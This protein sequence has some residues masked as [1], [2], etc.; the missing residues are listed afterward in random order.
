MINIYKASAGA[1]KTHKLTGEYLKLLFSDYNAYS[2]ILAVTFTNKATDEM[3]QRILLELY[4][5]SNPNIKSDYIDDL[6]TLYNKSHLDIRIQAKKILLEILYDY[7]AFSIS[8][9]D[10]F[11][12]KIMRAFARELGRNLT[13]EVEL[14]T[15]KVLNVVVDTMFS[16]LDLPEN[17]NLLNWLIKY[18][19]EAVE[20]GNSWNI[21]K[22]II[23]LSNELFSESF[24]LKKGDK[25]F[26]NISKFKDTL[27][28]IRKTFI[29]ELSKLIG[30]GFSIMDSFDLEYDDFKGGSRSAFKYFTINRFQENVLIKEPTAS[31]R[32]LYNDF[33]SKWFTGKEPNPNILSAYNS[34]LNDC[35]G[36]ILKHFDTYYKLYITSYVILN[37]INALGILDEVYMR[38]VNYCNQKN[39]MLIS[40]STELLNKIIGE[41]DTPFIYEKIGG[42]IDNFMLD[43]FQDTSLLQWNNFIPLLENSI[44]QGKENLI[45]GDVKQSIYRWRGSDWSILNKRVYECFAKDNIK[46]YNLEYN[47]RSGKNIVNFTNTFFSFCA[48]EIQNNYNKLAGVQGDVIENIYSGFEQMVPDKLLSKESYVEVNFFED[49]KTDEAEILEQLPKRISELLETGVEKKDIAILVRKKDEGRI[50]A[51]KLIALNIDVISNDSLFI[52]ASLAVQKIIS[53]LRIIANPNLGLQNIFV[54]L[55]KNKP[56][57]PD[58]LQGKSIYE[59]CEEI[60]RNSFNDNEKMELPYLQAFLDCALDFSLNEGADIIGFLKWWDEIGRGKTISA[61]DDADAINIITIHKSKGLGFKVVIIPFFNE[62]LE[63]INSRIWSSVDQIKQLGFDAPLPI[64][65]NSNLASSYFNKDFIQEKLFMYVD[66]L[67]TAYVACTRAKDQLI[68]YSIAPTEKSIADD[69]ISAIKDVL[70]KYFNDV[71][72]D[73]LVKEDNKEIT[74]FS[75]GNIPNYSNS[76]TKNT[77]MIIK[78]VFDNKLDYA[79]TRLSLTTDSINED[80]SIRNFGIAMH[81]IFSLIKYKSDID[82]AIDLAINEG[83]CSND[84]IELKIQIESIIQSVE[85]YGWFS[86]DNKILNECDIIKPSGSVSRPDRI[87]IKENKAII[88]DYKFGKYQDDSLMLNKYKRQITEY[89]ILLKE[90]GYKDVESYIW[91][92]L[93]RIIV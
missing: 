66:N 91:Y 34:G 82:Q 68:I 9:I 73:G 28:N 65:Y 4:N 69:K 40:E 38:I 30:R 50:V 10:K 63:R 59:T 15:T 71:I 45:V 76:D 61:P 46:D 83:V 92:P 81:Y 56:Y 85:D 33:D 41:D 39:V 87:I 74:K 16:E 77:P 13:Y 6:A 37:N 31:F 84:K 35:I 90:L 58:D 25:K 23:S 24:K 48:K 2:K 8:T 57:I 5:L 60:I 64:P 75:I 43:E 27:L 29:G 44:A 3:K 14:D 19:V 11:F 26:D 86:E 17:K 51:A 53:T 12:Q 78:G 20:N 88:V 93:D 1:G 72:I 67:N 7:T 55:F 79:K 21:K 22:E 32:A 18:S 54:H 80:N 36:S 89:V 47:W 70:Y 62:P 49:P 42:R 52:G